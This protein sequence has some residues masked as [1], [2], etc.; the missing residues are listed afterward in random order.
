VRIRVRATCGHSVETIAHTVI[1][2]LPEILLRYRSNHLRLPLK[3]GR[4][5][6]SP[7][8]GDADLQ[9]AGYGKACTAC[10]ES[11]AKCVFRSNSASCLKCERANR[12]CQPCVTGPRRARKRKTP[13]S[14]HEDAGQH[15]IAR[16]EGKLDGLV[17]VICAGIESGTVALDAS[18]K[19]KLMNLVDDDDTEEGVTLTPASNL[20]IREPS[21]VAPDGPA[22][23]G[24]HE[25]ISPESAEAQSILDTFRESA[26]TQLP[27]V[28]LPKSSVEL[29]S[30]R[31]YLW[32]CC[33]GAGTKVTRHKTS[34]GQQMKE[35]ISREA[36]LKSDRTRERTFDLLLGHLVHITWAGHFGSKIMI[37]VLTQVAIML[38]FE[39]GLNRPIYSDTNPFACKWKQPYGIPVHGPRTM[40]E[41]RAVLG[42]FMVT[43]Q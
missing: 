14:G 29:Y 31:P 26:I 20:S 28:R 6:P 38:V 19:E 21:I 11:K 40:E 35:V 32:L 33:M 41:R 8:K 13:D 39:M 2:R 16:L 42:V 24:P 4:I 3:A 36:L 43:S 37:S 22:V 5:M 17:S 34:I 12:D 27:F 10:A 18:T 7:H 25:I 30:Q 9:P 15:R 1:L 23:F